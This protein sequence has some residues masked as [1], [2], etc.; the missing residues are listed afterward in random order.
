[1]DSISNVV[2]IIK[3]E[4][5][6]SDGFIHSEDASKIFLALSKA[7][8]DIINPKKS[9]VN[10][11]FKS[12]YADLSVIIDACRLPLSINEIAC[13]QAPYTPKDGTVGVETLF[14][15]SSGQFIKFRFKIKPNKFDIQSVGSIITYIKRFS[16][17]SALLIV[18]D[19]DDDDGNAG[20]TLPIKPPINVPKIDPTKVTKEQ[21]VELTN[22]IKEKDI[23]REALLE[24]ASSVC[25]RKIDNSNQLNKT[26]MNSLIENIKNNYKNKEEN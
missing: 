17:S 19:N 10:P 8:G 23:Q 14:G 4:D 5:I 25:N 18:G 12:K 9:I 3:S 11:F 1:M 7:Q 20:I 6:E 21:S 15:H 2:N 22:L 24:I 26:E 16:L 13:M